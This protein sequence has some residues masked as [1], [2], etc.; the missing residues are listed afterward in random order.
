MMRVR[1]KERGVE[2]ELAAGERLL[3]AADDHPVTGL[4]PSACRAGNCGA[5]LLRVRTGAEG[6]APP[7][8]AERA[9]LQALGAPPDAR[10]GCQLRARPPSGTA[11]MTAVAVLALVAPAKPSDIR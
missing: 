2:L 11:A 1:L 9:T 5:C 8:A 4:L 3:D 7:E 10:L 6:F